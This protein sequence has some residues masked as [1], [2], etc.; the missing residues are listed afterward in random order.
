MELRAAAVD[1][2]RC[3]QFISEK[4]NRKMLDDMRCRIIAQLVTLID[5]G[6]RH[7]I[8]SAFGCGAFRNPADN[9]A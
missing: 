8:L 3:G 4:F 9:V 1:R 6:V 2:R 7:V 5:A